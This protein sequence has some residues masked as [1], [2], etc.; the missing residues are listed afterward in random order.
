MKWHINSFRLDTPAVISKV[1]ELFAVHPHLMEGFKLFLP[2][3]SHKDGEAVAEEPLN[4][5]KYL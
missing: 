1:K 3:E 2:T 5:A 4:L